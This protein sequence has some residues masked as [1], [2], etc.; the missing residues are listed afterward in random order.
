MSLL[1]RINIDFLFLI[2]H[3]D[4]EAET[5]RRL[6]NGLREAGYLT[7]ILSIPFHAHKFGVYAPKVVVFPFAISQDTWPLSYFMQAR[8]SQTH[9]VSLS[10]EQYL[11]K[12]NLSFK[13]PRGTVV[14]KDLYHLAWIPEYKEFLSESGVDSDLISVIGSPNIELLQEQLSNLTLDDKRRSL[15]LDDQDVWFFPM[16]YGWAFF[17]DRQVEGKIKAGYERS[18]AYEY[19]DFSKKCLCEFVSFISDL[20]ISR[21]D[22]LFVIRPHPSVSV[23]QYLE[24]F[25]QCSISVPQNCLITKDYT[26]IDWIA[27]SNVVASSWST[28]V[29][30]AFNLGKSVFLFTPYQR[31]DWLNTF[32]NELV[33]NVKDVSEINAIESSD[34]TSVQ[35]KNVNGAIV[36][37]LESI[38]KSSRH[39]STKRTS[40]VSNVTRKMYLFRSMLYELSVRYLNGRFVPRGLRRDYFDS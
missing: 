21:P 11:S 9:L 35:I 17:S 15:G 29:W 39:A 20:A 40:N 3:E 16:N 34:T 5:V 19:R 37:W 25:D 24:V 10:W 14:T 4:R 31:P 22:V 1:S 28:V 32:W 18:I 38:L 33:I 27:V 26:V 8:Y 6:S 23:E 36:Q 12:A 2:E 13:K 7:V 30:D